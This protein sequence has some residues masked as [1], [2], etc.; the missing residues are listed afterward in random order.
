MDRVFDAPSVPRV[1]DARGRQRRYY[2][3]FIPGDEP[4]RT[5]NVGTSRP[6][7]EIRLR[8]EHGL[9]GTRSFTRRTIIMCP[10]RSE[11]RR[12]RRGL[13]ERKYPSRFTRFWVSR[14]PY[15]RQTPTAGTLRNG[16]RY[17]KS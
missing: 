17:A 8:V 16:V 2:F 4:K 5:V 3:I 15:T 14:P 9:L 1:R 10:N 12:W 7:Y 13:S 11:N 6:V